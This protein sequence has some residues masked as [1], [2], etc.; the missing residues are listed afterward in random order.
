MKNMFEK[1]GCDVCNRGTTYQD[2][3]MG[4]T[5]AMRCGCT[6]VPTSEYANLLL[7]KYD[8]TPREFDKLNSEFIDNN[9]S[10]GSDEA[11][12]DDRSW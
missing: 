5:H 11:W 8:I 7:M 3:G 4:F 10:C 12:V 2:I 1:P 9:K 6:R